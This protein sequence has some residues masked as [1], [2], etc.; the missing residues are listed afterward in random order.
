MRHRDSADLRD[1]SSPYEERKE[2]ISKCQYS[3]DDLSLLE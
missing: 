2:P 1:L 3:I